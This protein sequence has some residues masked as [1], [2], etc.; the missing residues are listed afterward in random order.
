VSSARVVKTV[1]CF[2]L[3]A[4]SQA[5]SPS[6]GACRGGDL[7]YNFNMPSNTEFGALQRLLRP[8]RRDLTIQLADSL[9]HL[10]ADPEVLARYD[11]LADKNTL[12]TLT[13]RERTEL[14]SLV[15]ANSLLAVLKAE[16]R[17]F[18]KQPK[19]A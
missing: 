6:T 2:P 13:S 9:V 5:K 3:C 10:K 7:G 16:A 14:E 4:F 8:L 18:L 1:T 15:R 11:R 17:A 12:G 19:A